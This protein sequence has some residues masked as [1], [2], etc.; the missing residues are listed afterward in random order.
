MT[1]M[2]RPMSCGGIPALDGPDVAGDEH[3]DRGLVVAGQSV[4]FDLTEKGD[5]E[6]PTAGRLRRAPACAP[7]S[8]PEPG[9]RHGWRSAPPTLASLAM[10]V[11][12][13][14]A[15]LAAVGPEHRVEVAVSCRSGLSKAR[16]R[17]AS[18][19]KGFSSFPAGPS[20]RRPFRGRTWRPARR[21]RLRR[22]CG[23]ALADR[24]DAADESMS[25]SRL[26]F[27]D[28]IGQRVFG[29]DA[30]RPGLRGARSRIG[31]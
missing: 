25:I 8:P 30:G 6:V 19:R 28:E 31:V 10:L 17:A 4:R 18:W 23:S 24:V 21:G 13:L 7:R 1:L 5:P 15:P 20:C 22:C 14:L 9:R 12:L 11:A 27:G 16:S 2:S 3:R 29:V 26:Q